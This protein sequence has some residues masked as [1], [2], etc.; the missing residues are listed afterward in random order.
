MAETAIG[1]FVMVFILAALFT[2]GRV[3]TD[4]QRYRSSVRWRS[5]YNA[6]Y[7]QAPFDTAVND[8]ILEYLGDGAGGV[9][10]ASLEIPSVTSPRT[11][12]I[13]Y[14]VDIRNDVGAFA[15][16]RVFGAD[17]IRITTG[18]YMPGMSVPGVEGGVE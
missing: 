16:D 1:L 12:S 11:E 9:G 10:S 7:G 4:S 14:E 3:I 8:S 17:S 5:G 13:S 15:A 2:F 6:Q 18:V